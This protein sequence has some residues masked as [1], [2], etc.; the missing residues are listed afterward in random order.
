MT[1][2]EK[3]DIS[4]GRVSKRGRNAGIA[5][6]GGGLAVIVLFVISQFVG[7]DLT[8]LAGP[9]Q[10]QQAEP[11][12]AL[13]QCQTGADANANVEC[14]VVG[15]AASLDAFWATE[16]PAMGGEYTPTSVQLFDASTN[17][18]CGAATSATG[19]FYCPG[20]QLIYIDT[21]FYA[22]LRDKY[23][24]SGGPLA[25][26]YVLAHE[27][28]H[29]IQDIAGILEQAQDGKS[30][31]SSNSVRVE[32]QADCFA[33]AWVGAASSTTDSAGE[34]FLNPVT[35]DQINDALSAAAAVGDDRIQEATQGQVTPHTFT[36]GSS[37]QRQR[38][39]MTG[40]SDGAGSCNTF[41]PAAGEL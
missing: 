31:E 7:V 20:D 25:E 1:F 9:A 28:G 22:E 8:G 14:R 26:M 6:G 13:E 40:Y 35:K 39:F 4:G 19:P 5:A 38:W 3:S 17:T 23:G 32:L 21:S 33:G 12:Q 2:N 24:S 30:G 11:G 41:A 37:E 15:A 10:P 27:W 29:H 34:P 18:A 36:H 16:L